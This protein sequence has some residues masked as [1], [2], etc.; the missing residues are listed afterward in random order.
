M[1]T[2]SLEVLTRVSS[3]K[4]KGC[5]LELIVKVFKQLVLFKTLGSQT[6]FTQ[7]SHLS[8]LIATGVFL[9][10]E[11]HFEKRYVCICRS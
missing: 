11:K 3:K 6:T 1:A 8:A 10:G 7:I 2:R 9:W 5:H 4:R